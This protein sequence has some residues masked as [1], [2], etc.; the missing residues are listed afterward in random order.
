M[1]RAS[2]RPRIVILLLS[3]LLTLAAARA[4]AADPVLIPQVIEPWWQ[5]AGDPDLGEW[6]SEGQQPVDFGVW[7]AADGTWQL[8][9]CIRKTKCGGSTRLFYRW[10][11]K[12]LT[13]PDWEPKGIAMTA[14]PK[15]G[16][17]P[18]GLQAP[19]VIRV[20][21]TYYM[22]YGDWCNIC[23]AHSRDGK[24]F[25]RVPNDQG[26]PQLFTE[27]K[28]DDWAN[29]RDPL[30]LP[31]GDTYHCYYAAFPGR[32]GAVY[33]RTS[34]DLR[35]WSGSK[36]V[37]F[38]GS[39][40]T[41]P[42]SAECPHVVDHAPSGYYYLFHTQRYG[43]HAQTSVYR[44]KDPMDFGIED[45]RCLVGRLAVAAPE[46][47]RH[48]GEWYI[49]SL[50]ASLKGIAIARLA[51][52]PRPEPG[53]SLFDFDD[54]AVRARWRRVEGD[55]E[56]VFTTS[57]RQLFDPPYTHFIGTAE[58]PRVPGRADD[59]RVGVIE[60]P[61]FALE[62]GRYICHVSGGANREKTYVAIV[63]AA[64]GDELVRL[65]GRESNRFEAVPVD[66][67]PHVGKRVRIRVVDTAT[68]GWGHV[69]FGGMFVDTSKGIQK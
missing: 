62:H 32:K 65:A 47:I 27:D 44:S 55:V 69:N 4:P 23:L 8:W 24:T 33:C 56:P 37:A 9:S 13:D 20:D 51:W 22:H 53:E 42:T 21:D 58:S 63:D 28:P 29:A 25:Q 36:I 17:T 26:R 18:G 35:T 5:V 57:T 54:P 64:T 59:A 45:D 48:D 46:I 34:K 10:E 15:L 60:S 7:Q 2:P 52:L 68:G 39:V 14:D 16:E 31:I 41:G 1:L 43:E 6:T 61:E 12:R 40:G 19:H 50:T 30:V 49:A 67:T 38:G 11:G 66:L 3:I